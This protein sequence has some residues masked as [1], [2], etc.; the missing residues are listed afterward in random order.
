M[1]AGMIWGRGG[2]HRDGGGGGSA[3]GVSSKV[4]QRTTEHY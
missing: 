3:T 4:V 1:S 2:F